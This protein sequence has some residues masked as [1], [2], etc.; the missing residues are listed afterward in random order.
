MYVP[1]PAESDNALTSRPTAGYLDRLD[2]LGALLRASVPFGEGVNTGAVRSV[3]Y[4]STEN[5]YSV[6]TSTVTRGTW[7]TQR[8]RGDQ[9]PTNLVP[10]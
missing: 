10:F 2:L 8:R 3:I 5:T 6:L 9:E 1:F 4:S 7:A